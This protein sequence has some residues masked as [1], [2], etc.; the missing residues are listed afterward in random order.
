MNIHKCVR[1]SL[2][3]PC[4]YMQSFGWTFGRTINCIPPIIQKITWPAP[5]THTPITSVATGVRGRVATMWW[6]GGGER[7]TEQNL[8]SNY[9]RFDSENFRKWVRKSHQWK[10]GK[11]QLKILIIQKMD[12]KHCTGKIGVNSNLKRKVTKNS[13]WKIWDENF[14]STNGWKKWAL[15]VKNIGGCLSIVL[16]LMV[17]GCSQLTTVLPDWNLQNGPT[18]KLRSP[19]M[20]QIFYCLNRTR[21]DQKS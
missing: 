5:L 20:P 19:R 10:A 7:C 3:G 2:M 15:L 8:L 17:E 18:A 11:L 4:K 16:P 13:N 6:R 1:S 9:S 21:N 12:R 14:K